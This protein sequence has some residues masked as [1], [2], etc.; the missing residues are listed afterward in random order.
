MSSK[1]YFLNI[2]KGQLITNLVPL[3]LKI[4]QLNAI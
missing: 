3:A 4:Y 1:I 2:L